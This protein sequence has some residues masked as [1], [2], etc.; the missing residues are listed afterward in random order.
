MSRIA[1]NELKD[2][3]ANGG[4]T[5]TQTLEPIAEGLQD[6]DNS[7]EVESNI[8]WFEEEQEMKGIVI[9][10]NDDIALVEEVDEVGKRTGEFYEIEYAEAK[11][12]TFVVTEKADEMIEKG[13]IVSWGTSKGEYYGD[14]AEVITKGMARGEPQGLEIEGSKENPAY[15]VRV[16]MQ[17][18]IRDLPEDYDGGEGDDKAESTWHMT[19]TTVVARGDG[20]K[21]EEALPTGQEEDDYNYGDDDEE[22]AMK[23]IDKEF[24]AQVEELIKAN[25]V[26]L[27]RLAEFDTQEKSEVVVDEIVIAE[28]VVDEVKSEQ[29]VATTQ[30]PVTEEVKTEE[31][32]TEEAIEEVKTE[33]LVVEAL[34]EKLETVIEEVVAEETSTIELK[35]ELTFDDLKEFHNLLKDISN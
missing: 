6:M 28:V 2:S 13:A 20:L 10:V 23:S 16:W 30:E 34:E 35:G 24:R 3:G 14:V 31:A 1:N 5:L 27:E 15:V 22:P 26:I 21:V 9:D 33:E 11:L 12:R 29:E 25:S 8:S 7:I 32:K 4:T 17:A 19:N 18:D